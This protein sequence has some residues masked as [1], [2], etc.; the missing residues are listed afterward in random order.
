MSVVSVD[1]SVGHHFHQHEQ[2]ACDLLLQHLKTFQPSCCF[3]FHPNF[4]ADNTDYKVHRHFF[5]DFLNEL[6]FLCAECDANGSPVRSV[7][8]RTAARV[9]ARPALARGEAARAAAVR[10]RRG[11]FLHRRQRGHPFVLELRV[12]LFFFLPGN[13]QPT[14]IDLYVGMASFVSSL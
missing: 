7:D 5:P 1:S 14:C 12:S 9:R 6:V 3:S 11:R 8:V 2:I 10:R 13:K 4:I